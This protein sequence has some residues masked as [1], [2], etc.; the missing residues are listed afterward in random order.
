ML[1]TFT[2]ANNGQ[3]FALNPKF[4]VGV[5]V[6]VEDNVKDKTLIALSTGTVVVKESYLEVVGL[7]QGELH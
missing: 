3:T 5:F 6:G 4:I 1:L 7:I 2:D